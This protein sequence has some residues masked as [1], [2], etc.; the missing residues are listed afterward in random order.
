MGASPEFSTEQV[1]HPADEFRSDDI[2][3]T[4]FGWYVADCAGLGDYR[5]HSLDEYTPEELCNGSL[6]EIFG[7]SWSIYQSRTHMAAKFGAS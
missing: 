4:E 5:D 2:E 1:I 3:L 7:D 6:R